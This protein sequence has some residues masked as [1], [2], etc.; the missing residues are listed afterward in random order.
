MFVTDVTDKHPFQHIFK[1]GIL[2]NYFQKCRYI[3]YIRYKTE[4]TLEFFL[5]YVIIRCNINCLDNR[6]CNII[7]RYKT[8]K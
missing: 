5:I 6:F 2:Q 3:R 1:V 8:E 7:I 4:Y